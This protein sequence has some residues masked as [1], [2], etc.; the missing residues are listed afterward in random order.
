MDSLLNKFTKFLYAHLL[1]KLPSKSLKGNKAL[2][3]K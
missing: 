2:I 1:I 3:N